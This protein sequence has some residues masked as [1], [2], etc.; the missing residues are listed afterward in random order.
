MD[1][2]RALDEL[3]IDRNNFRVLGLL[4]L[5]YV[6]WA[7]GTVQTAEKKVIYDLARNTGWVNAAGAKVLKGWLENEP[8]KEYTQRGL[9][10]LSALAEGADKRL[11]VSITPDSLAY[12]T[13]MCGRVAAAAG[14]ALG[15][16]N[17][18]DEEEERALEEIAAAFEIKD[19]SSWQRLVAAT[20]GE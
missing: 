14:G 19:A 17:P 2:A 18:I 10:L 15:L 13:V 1:V 6:A 3:G 9:S 5:V 7:D 11:G 12:L 20:G 16:Q 8:S 4:P